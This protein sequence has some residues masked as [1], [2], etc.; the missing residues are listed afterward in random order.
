MF[1]KADK[2]VLNSSRLSNPNLVA[3]RSGSVIGDL[4]AESYIAGRMSATAR[5]S[6]KFNSGN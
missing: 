3:P 6:I 1:T 4:M 2:A 5:I